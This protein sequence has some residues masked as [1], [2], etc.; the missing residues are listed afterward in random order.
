MRNNPLSLDAL[1]RIIEQVKEYYV[2]PPLQRRRG[3]PRVFSGRAFLLLAVAAVVLRPSKPQ[4][5][6]TLLTKDISL[7]QAL[8]LARV[9]HRRT[10]ERRLGATLPEAEA[11]VQAL[12]QQILGEV[13]PE[14]DQPRASAIDG[15]MCQAQ[16][17][18]WHA[19]DRV[20]VSK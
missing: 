15:R 4:E 14:P 11:Q 13:E 2:A 19:R 10:L 16:G 7:R 8:G 20:V 12:G 18:L 5:L 6:L 1:L 9:P 3:R 17:P